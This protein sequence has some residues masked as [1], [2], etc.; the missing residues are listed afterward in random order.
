MA[1]RSTKSDLDE[2][3]SQSNL[4]Q[5]GYQTHY[6]LKTTN[7]NIDKDGQ[8]QTR[9]FRERNPSKQNKTI[10]LVGETGSGKSTMIN[11]MVNHHLGIECGNNLWFEIVEEEE[12]IQTESQTRVVTVYEIFWY[13]GRAPYSLTIID[14]PGFGDTRGVD[15]D[16]LVAKKLLEL[17]MCQSGMEL[18]AIGFVVKSTENRCSDRQKYIFHAILSLFGK[19]V[20]SNLVAMFTHS[21]GLP[22]KDALK[23]LEVERI[24][25]ARDDKN[26][27]KYFLFD[28]CQK[29]SPDGAGERNEKQIMQYRKVMTNG[30]EML[31]ENMEEL[32]HFLSKT[33]PQSLATTRSVLTNRK[34]LDATITNTEDQITAIE[35][36]QKQLQELHEAVKSHEG[37]MTDFKYQIDENYKTRVEFTPDFWRL[38]KQST[39]CLEC[40]ENCHYPGCWWVSDLSWCSVMK[41]NHCTVCSGGC[42]YSKHVQG[43]FLW[44]TKTRKVT[45]TC[46][47]LKKEYDINKD[48]VDVKKTL[49]SVLGN[50]LE[51]AKLERDALLEKAYHCVTKLKEAAL[52]DFSENN[53]GPIC[54]LL[55]RLG[56]E[57]EEK[58]AILRGIKNHLQNRYAG[59]NEGLLG[60][61]VLG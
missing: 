61:F 43:H 2:I 58:L 50:E 1:N 36:K 9:T 55:E 28:N 48:E 14:T 31:M 38:T 37:N 59:E 16:A 13:E 10:L 60:M 45:K 51:E 6:R 49:I 34:V 44:K 29:A 32:S 20:Q 17:F 35:M 47:D 12:R 53:S 56:P 46:E 11:A 39:V 5:A 26:E 22:P 42:H 18:D 8:I 27:P 33:T 21:N 57:N 30:W 19:N 15:E 54:F 7:K 41:A 40:Q 23:A 3:I 4:I 25:L 52:E 24:P